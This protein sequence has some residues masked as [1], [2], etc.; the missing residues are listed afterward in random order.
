MNQI[1]PFAISHFFI[2]DLM[3]LV[4]ANIDDFTTPFLRILHNPK[5]SDSFVGITISNDPKILDGDSEKYQDSLESIIKFIVLNQKVLL[6]HWNL[7]Y[8]TTQLA[9]KLVFEI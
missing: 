5:Q 1:D 9:Q 2:K 7:E 4:I 3:V 8:S 6:K